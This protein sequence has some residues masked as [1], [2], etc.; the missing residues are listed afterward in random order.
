[1]GYNQMQAPERRLFDDAKDDS[2]VIKVGYHDEELSEMCSNLV[3]S[4]PKR[5]KMLVKAKRGHISY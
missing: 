2:S 3:E 5:E 4:I 1:M